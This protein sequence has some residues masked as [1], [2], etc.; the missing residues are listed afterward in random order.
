MAKL[1]LLRTWKPVL[2]AAST[3]AVAYGTTKWNS[4]SKP[5]HILNRSDE[6]L[7]SLFKLLDENHTGFV[8]ENA[9]KQALQKEGIAI[10]QLS[11]KSMIFAADVDHDGKLSLEE[12]L[13][14][15]HKMQ[16]QEGF[17]R[18]KPTEIQAK[19]YHFP[20]ETHVDQLPHKHKDIVPIIK[21]ISTMPGHFP[22]KTDDD[23]LNEK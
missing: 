12:F 15:C 2:L 20:N 13:H 17:R 1:L 5:L 18:T 8:D 11:L 10:S 6:E 23:S 22:A 3:I 7:N 14:I 19:R 21:P 9:L 4:V 16:H